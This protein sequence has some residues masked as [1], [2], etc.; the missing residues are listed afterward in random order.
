VPADRRQFVE[1]V[2]QERILVVENSVE[3][4]QLLAEFVLEPN[5]YRSLTAL[6]G[7]AGLRLALQE[8]PDLIV[9]DMQLPG[10]S[11]IEVLRALREQGVDIPI[12]CTTGHE[13]VEMVVQAFR[14]GARDYV[15]KPFGPMEMQEAIRRALSSSTVREEQEQLNQKLGDDHR[16]G[17]QV[18]QFL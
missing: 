17:H 9:V 3:T 6:D 12:I 14:L 15:L 10:M 11:G 16:F 7:E 5:D 8:G 2:S 1:P 13:S 18:K 4:Q